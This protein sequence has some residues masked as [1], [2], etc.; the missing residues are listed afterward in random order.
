MPDN[1]TQLN[2]LKKIINSID[3]STRKTLPDD[4]GYAFRY[5]WLNKFSAL[6]MAPDSG[7]NI[8]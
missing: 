4:D 6:V 8:A 5:I 3:T 7:V 1:P 2:M